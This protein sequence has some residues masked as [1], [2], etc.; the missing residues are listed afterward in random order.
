MWRFYNSNLVFCPQ[1]NRILEEWSIWKSLSMVETFR[2]LCFT[3]LLLCL[4]L[5]F[6]PC[7]VWR[8]LF[9]ATF[10]Y[11]TLKQLRTNGRHNQNTASFNF[12]LW[13]FITCLDKCTSTLPLHWGREVLHFLKITLY[14]SVIYR[15]NLTLLSAVHGYDSIS[16]VAAA[17]I[18]PFP[19]TCH[20]LFSSGIWLA[21]LFLR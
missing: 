5:F 21:S 14:S 9:C 11:G 10:V 6:I 20:F 4:Y 16:T 13:T 18:E 3:V 2:K 17:V 8:H 15:S 12:S 19:V 7:F 1:E